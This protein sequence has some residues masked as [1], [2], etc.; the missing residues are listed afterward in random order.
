M[1]TIRLILFLILAAPSWAAISSTIEWDV[2]TTGAD[3]N[4]GGFKPGATGTDFSQQDSAQYALT[5]LT[6]SGISTTIASATSA[7]DMVGNIIQITGGTNFITGF[8]E[9]VS[10]SLGVSITLDRNCTSGIGAAGTGNVGGG[11]LTVQKGNDGAINSNTVWIKYHAT[12]KYTTTTGTTFTNTGSAAAPKAFRGYEVTHGDSTGNKPLMTTATDSTVLCKVGTV[13]GCIWRNINFSNTAS[14]RSRA[15]S[16]NAGYV[17]WLTFAGCKFTGFTDGIEFSDI[18]DYASRDTQVNSC[19]FTTITGNCLRFGG[20][21]AVVRGCKFYS[22]TGD[23]ILIE[24]SGVGSASIYSSLFSQVNH[25]INTDS[26]T[27]SI[28][29]SNVLIMVDQ[30]SFANNVSDDI[31]IQNT[32]R[33]IN[34]T[35][36]IGYN[37]GTGGSGKFINAPNQLPGFW[38]NYNAYASGDLTNVTAGA[39]DVNITGDPFTASGSNDFSL[40]NTAGAGA[41]CRNAG[42][43]SAT[44]PG[45][46]G[47]GYGDIGA[48]R[49]QD[50]GGAAVQVSY[51]SAN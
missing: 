33:A 4:G 12:N 23:G 22:C 15:F 5:G 44:G 40:N 18:I 26:G 8:Y 11:L 31:L 19:E 7:A 34:V 1:K 50:A 9:I 25:G 46:F 42:F 3:T 35:N 39:S 47:A 16:S 13:T 14:V 29:A 48:L 45:T 30:C 20:G 27:D 49:H 43:P 41:T 2:R 36:C 24:V 32:T 6:T 10:V 37:N 17:G 28:P 21:T 51:G 38:F